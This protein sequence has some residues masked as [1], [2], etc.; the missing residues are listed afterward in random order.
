[1]TT[2]V[3]SGRGERLLASLAIG[4]LLYLIGHRTE[5]RTAELD[6]DHAPA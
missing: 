3:G 4:V 6:Y 2:T 5:A 1:M